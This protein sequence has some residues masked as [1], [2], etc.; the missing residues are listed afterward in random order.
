MCGRHIAYFRGED[1]VVYAV[2]AY[3]THMGANL[4][5]GKVKH[6]N[7]IEYWIYIYIY[8]RCPFHGWIYD[9]KTGNCVNSEYKDPKSVNFHRYEDITFQTPGKI[10]EC[11]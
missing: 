5:G 3:C 1:G 6:G 10:V 11:E 7:C 8:F 4:G 9:G 2:Q